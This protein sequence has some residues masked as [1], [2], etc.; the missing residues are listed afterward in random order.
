MLGKIFEP[1]TTTKHQSQG[2]GLGMN[3]T[4]NFIVTSMKGTISAENT[5]FNYKGKEVRRC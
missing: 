5:K 2:T 4:Y 3:I 1:Y